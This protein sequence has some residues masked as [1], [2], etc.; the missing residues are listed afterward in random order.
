MIPCA[1]TVS[2]ALLH[3]YFPL[4]NTTTSPIYSP[5]TDTI[6]FR[7][8]FYPCTRFLPSL[9]I[10]ISCLCNTKI[11]SMVG[12]VSCTHETSAIIAKKGKFRPKRNMRHRA[13]GN[14]VNVCILIVFYFPSLPRR[15][16]PGISVYAHVFQML[17]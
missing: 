1:G 14:R 5:T 3:H 11:V 16:L 10:Y 2:S 12:V 9:S 6:L 4:L 8:P 13:L 7:L 15:V 17:L